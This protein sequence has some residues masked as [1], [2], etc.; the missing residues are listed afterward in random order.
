MF[1]RDNDVLC[2]LVNLINGYPLKLGAADEWRWK[3]ESNGQYTTKGAYNCLLQQKISIHDTEKE[4][5]KM[6][7]N[8]L[9]PKKKAKIHFWRVLWERIPSKTKL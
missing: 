1:Y 3:W 2:E 5:F 4:E 8:K 6:I 7:W 9:V